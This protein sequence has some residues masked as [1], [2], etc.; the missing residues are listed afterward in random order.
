VSTFLTVS[1]PVV[2]AEIKFI[3]KYVQLLNCI[4]I[5]YFSASYLLLPLIFPDQLLM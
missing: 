5:A 4:F 3:K 2:E 1:G